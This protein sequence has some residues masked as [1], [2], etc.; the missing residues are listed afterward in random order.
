MRR[1]RNVLRVKWNLKTQQN[2]LILTEEHVV[3]EIIDR[4]WLQAKIR[5]V[6]I[7]QPVGGV[8]RKNENGI[9][10][11]SGELPKRPFTIMCSRDAC[12]STIIELPPTPLWIEVKR[13][14]RPG[15]PAGVPSPAQIRFID[16]KKA[17]GCAAF[18][19]ESWFDVVRELYPFGIKLTS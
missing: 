1:R 10:D 19:A 12:G 8:V 16:E 18:F 6:R 11:L 7:N 4:L 14:G 13:P 9:P 3:Q 2:E 17:A 15:L 5:M